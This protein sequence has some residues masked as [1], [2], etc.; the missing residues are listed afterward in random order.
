MRPGRVDGR[1]FRDTSA[2]RAALPSPYNTYALTTGDAAYE[3]DREDLQVLYR[4]LF[5]TSFLLADQV[6]ESVEADGS[7][8]V[9]L[10][11]ASS[12]TAYGAAFAL[13]DALVGRRRVELVGLTSPANAAFTRDLGVYDSVLGYDE[14]EQ[15]DADAAST[16]LDLAG[17]TDLRRRLHA[18]LGAALHSDLVIGVTHQDSTS[19]GTLDGARPTVFFAPER[20]RVRSEQWGREE[21]DERFAAA[22]QLFA[23]VVQGW[24]D[25]VVSRGPEA[26]QHVWGEVLAGRS[27]PREGHVV[28]L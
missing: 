28:V 24:V 18:H 25:V 21:L 6:A 7:A 27:A 8:V 10:S 11:S 23:P 26:L 1:G 16:Y 14:V 15:L 19:A 3:P 4:P 17:S 22:W 20:M 2:H 5:F 13:R 12:K 9:A